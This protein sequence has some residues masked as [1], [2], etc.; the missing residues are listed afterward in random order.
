VMLLGDMRS[1]NY[2]IDVTP[3]FDKEQYRTRPIDFDQFC[4]E[5]RKNNYRPQFYKENSKVVQFCM[6]VLTPETVNQYQYEERSLMKKR[7]IISKKRV[8]LLMEALTDQRISTPEKRKSLCADLNEFHHTTSFNR[9]RS[10]GSILRKHM[11][12]MLDKP[13]IKRPSG[14][15]RYKKENKK[16]K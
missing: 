2:V 11:D 8:F 9:L 1:Y 12:L 10:M 5:G 13:R 14:N 7:Y 6:D 3:D 4:Y 16:K 15:V